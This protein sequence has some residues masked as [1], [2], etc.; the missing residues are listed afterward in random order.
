MAKYDG[1][2]RVKVRFENGFVS[3][4]GEKAAMILQGRKELKILGDAPAEVKEEPK[5]VK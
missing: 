4:L 3:F 2:K 5:K 1:G